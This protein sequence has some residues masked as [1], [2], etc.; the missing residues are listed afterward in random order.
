[1]EIIKDI[2]EGI[3]MAGSFIRGTYAPSHIEILGVHTAKDG[4]NWLVFGNM[5]T[6]H[7]PAYVEYSQKDENTVTVKIGRTDKRRRELELTSEQIPVSLL[8]AWEKE[9]GE[10]SSL[11][12]NHMKKGCP[13][14]WISPFAYNKQNHIEAA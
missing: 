1:M 9:R 12:T 6:H 4:S 14:L 13:C 11:N 8:G 5:E 10:L 2:Q 7:W 3:E